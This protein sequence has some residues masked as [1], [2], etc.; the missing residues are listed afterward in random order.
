MKRAS[1]RDGIQ[2]IA[3]NDEPGE[4]DPDCVAGFISVALLA[5]LFG[6]DQAQVAADVV[7][8]RVREAAQQDKRDR[9]SMAA[10]LEYLHQ[11]EES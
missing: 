9:E 3:Q 1:Y 2:W 5:D 6:K 10:E 11:Q 8:V 7:R 4:M